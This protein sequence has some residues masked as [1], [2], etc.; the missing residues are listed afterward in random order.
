TIQATSEEGHGSEFYFHLHLKKVIDDTQIDGSYRK[1]DEF[2]LFL[3]EPESEDIN[4]SAEVK[5]TS[6]VRSNSQQK[7]ETLLPDAALPSTPLC[8]PVAP[9]ELVS[10]VSK[11]DM[12]NSST[13]LPF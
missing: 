2:S 9:I 5:G 7:M 1:L 8:V 4:G 12:G 11:M 3:E 13:V 6:H 10:L